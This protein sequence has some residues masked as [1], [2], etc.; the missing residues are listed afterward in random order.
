MPYVLQVSGDGDGDGDGKTVGEGL[1]VAVT[2]A[3]SGSHVF[4]GHPAFSHA[5]TL[6]WMY[7]NGQDRYTKQFT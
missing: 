2:V 4:T 7:E 5:T 3:N 6:C 1:G